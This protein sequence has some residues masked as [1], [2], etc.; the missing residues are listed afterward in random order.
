M[1]WP[2]LSQP[3]PPP[4]TTRAGA[5]QTLPAF[6]L[7]ECPYMLFELPFIRTLTANLPCGGDLR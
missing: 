4:P 1:A 2:W 7:P 5:G 6:L 3:P